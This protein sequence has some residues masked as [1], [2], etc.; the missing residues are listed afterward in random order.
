MFYFK[1]L[2]FRV[3]I[4]SICFIILI[5]SFYFYKNT[6]LCYVSLPLFYLNLIK[7]S[8]YFIYTHPL[9]LAQVLILLVVFF[10]LVFFI[11]YFIWSFFDFLKSSLFYYEYLFFKK[12]LILF[13]IIF[14]INIFCFKTF[15][16]IIWLFFESFNTK[17]FFNIYVK[18][19]IRVGEYIIFLMQYF[20]LINILIFLIFLLYTFLYFK[21]ASFL[22]KT[23]KFLLFLNI[24]IATFLSPPD[25]FSQLFLF[26]FLY[27]ILEFINFSIIYNTKIN[28]VAY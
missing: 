4:S 19:E 7:F 3:T 12:F 27:I 16:P 20:I 5:L 21:T 8:G 26:C 23:K 10:S 1:E 24:L 22:L 17:F 11:P 14:F 28:K 6:L 13:I 18:M 9:E 25:V 15:F 2:Y